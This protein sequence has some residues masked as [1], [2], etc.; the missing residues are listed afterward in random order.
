MIQRLQS[1]D[2]DIVRRAAV[3]LGHTGGDPARI[4]LR[5]HLREHRDEN[6]FPACARLEIE[7]MRPVS[8]RSLQS[9]HA[10]SRL[11]LGL[12]YLRDVESIPLLAETL[13]HIGSRDRQS[14]SSRGGCG[15]IGTDASSGGRCGFGSGLC[16]TRTVPRLHAGMATTMHLMAC[17]ASPLHCF[18]TEALGCAA[19]R[20]GSQHCS[21]SN[22]FAPID[23]DRALFLGNDDREALVGRVVRRNAAEAAVVE[24]CLAILGDPQAVRNQEV[25]ESICTI[26]RCWGGE[27]TPE[28]RAAQVLSA[29]CRD[30]KYE[31]RVLAALLRYRQ[32]TVDI[33]RVFDTGIPVVDALPT[34]NWV[35]F[36][37]ARS[38]GNLAQRDSV[39]ALV[40]VLEQEPAEAATGRPDPLGV[41]V[42]FLH[43]ELTPCW[44]AAVAWALGRIG[45]P[46]AAP[47]LLEI[48]ADLNNATDTRHAAADALGQIGDPA[49]LE[50]IRKLAVDYPEIS[51]RTTLL[52]ILADVDAAP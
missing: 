48:V 24:T 44:R 16:C 43:N 50:V 14:L 2:R 32:H 11:R 47:V 9:I 41:G 21:P 10:R 1:P 49:S 38:L 30:A 36:Y 18:I 31:P 8:I 7:E 52:R 20:A 34:K 25:E 35:C 28:N 5:Q 17:H 40:E 37:L 6:P 45:D 22:P 39:D 23:P 26:H 29:V 3:A 46:R 4:A 33:P 51:T 27:P 13:A 15:S 42:M 19:M 12:G